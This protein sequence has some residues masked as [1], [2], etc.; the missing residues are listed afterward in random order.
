MTII[1]CPNCGY[2]YLP[3][4]IYYPDSLLGKPSDITRTPE[5]KIDFYTGSTMDLTETFECPHCG[6]YFSVSGDINFNTNIISLTDN[7]ETVYKLK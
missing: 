3:A 4:E 5:G 2:E 6:C 7:D 1:K